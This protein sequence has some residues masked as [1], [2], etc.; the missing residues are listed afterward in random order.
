MITCNKFSY[1]GGRYRQVSLYQQL[2]DLSEMTGVPHMKVDR[3][4]MYVQTHMCMYIWIYTYLYLICVSM[5][6]FLSCHFILTPVYR[7][8]LTSV[9]IWNIW[10][11]SWFILL[12]ENSFI[13]FTNYLLKAVFILKYIFVFY[14]VVYIVHSPLLWSV[15][16]TYFQIRAIVFICF[17]FISSS[18]VR[19]KV[20]TPWNGVTFDDYLYSVYMRSKGRLVGRSYVFS[21]YFMHYFV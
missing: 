1:R 11:L 14:H 16:S 7:S 20:V 3:M 21:M 10:Q 4:H 19:K 15:T 9:V 13:S 17:C 6:V 2:S 5:Y 12:R 18:T 8:N